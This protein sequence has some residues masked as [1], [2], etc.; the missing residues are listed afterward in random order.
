MDDNTD[1]RERNIFAN[2]EATDKNFAAIKEYMEA[3]RAVTQEQATEIQTLA[4]LVMTLNNR[5]DQQQQQIGFLQ[6][7]VL[8]GAATG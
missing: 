3:T 7:K 6:G 8:G 4:N 1:E 5:I 2:R